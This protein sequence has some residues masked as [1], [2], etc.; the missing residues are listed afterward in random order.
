MATD[1][2]LTALD[3]LLEAF[4]ARRKWRALARIER[5]L[6]LALQKAF[7]SQGRAF[8]S[9]LNHRAGVLGGRLQEAAGDIMP[10]DWE[11]LFA[12]IASDARLFAMPLQEAIQAALLV[13]AGH[14]SADFAVEAAFDLSNPRA[15][16]YLEAHA[17]T[18]VA[19]INEASRAE[20]RQIIAAGVRDG[21]SYDQIARTIRER[22]EGF[23]TPAPQQHIRS[24]AHLVA[25]TEAGDA[26][27]EGNRAVVDDLEAAGLRI[28]KSWLDVGDGRVDSDCESNAAAGWI[29]RADTFPSGDQ[30]PTAHPA[31]RCTTL[32]RLVRSAVGVAA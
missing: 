22:F 20:I 23:G 6:E 3:H 11:A 5:K 21:Q 29:P 2:T 25:A 30:A 24:R 14:A 4:T 26:Y 32:Y 10:P 27:E 17:A 9:A 19:G 16:A 1:S 8:L 7:R 15:A 18:T 12:V 28:E 13:G 31:C